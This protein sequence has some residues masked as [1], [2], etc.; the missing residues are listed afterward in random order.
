MNPDQFLEKLEKE[1]ILER[2]GK[3]VDIN[4]ELGSTVYFEWTFG[5]NKRLLIFF[6][7]NSITYFKIWGT[8]NNSKTENGIIENTNDVRKIMKDFYD[9]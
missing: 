9:L 3:P 1:K 5:N 8:G 4:K 2:Y 6:D 7:E